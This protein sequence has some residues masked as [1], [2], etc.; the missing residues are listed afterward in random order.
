MVSQHHLESFFQEMKCNGMASFIEFMSNVQFDKAMLFEKPT[1]QNGA[2][3]EV[4][5]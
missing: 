3:L 1:L 2:Q 5:G 4:I